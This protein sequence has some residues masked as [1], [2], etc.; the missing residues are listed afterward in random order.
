MNPFDH[1]LERTVLVRA[2]RATVFRYF[3]D[4]ERWMA[5][6]GK[7]STID[8]RPGGRALICY[9][10]GIE[11]AGEVLEIEPPR[12]FRFTYGFVSGQPIAPGSSRV[13]IDLAEHAVGTRLSLRHE[14]A[15]AEVRDHHVQGWRYQ[16]AVFANV[17]ADAHHAG[18]AAAADAWFAAWSE[19][20]TARRESV[21]ESVVSPE[22]RFRDR[23]SNVE[24]LD[25]LRPHLAALH[26]FM[27]GSRVERR[28]DVSHCQ[29]TLVAAWVAFGGDGKELGT[30]SN[31]F[32]LGPEGRI[33]DVV[34]LWR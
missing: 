31:V 10:G 7:G 8:P 12:R 26:T 13:T 32:T 20:D 29:G 24:G 34:G 3:T 1:S 28:G 17:V 27:P 30:G 25:D 23:Y 6:W 21:L 5:W 9:P 22:V 19:P 33:V 15:E 4:P 11:A 2:P 16:L 14:F 18:A